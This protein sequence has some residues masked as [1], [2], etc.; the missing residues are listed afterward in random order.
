VRFFAREAV[1]P[2]SPSSAVDRQ[3]PDGLFCLVLAAGLSKR[4]GSAKQLADFRGR[5][6][7]AH[8]MHLAG[9]VFGRASIL[10]AGNQWSR[11]TAAA[12]PLEG[13]FVVNEQYRHGL[14]SSIAA[15]ASVVGGCASGVMLLMADQPLIEASYLSQMIDEWNRDRDRIVVSQFDGVVGPPVIFPSRYFDELRA[16]DGDNGARKII[17]ANVSSLTRLPCAAAATDIDRKE[18]LER[19]LDRIR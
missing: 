2:A 11:V 7:I 14:G 6:M 9:E 4:F 8:T 13:F 16:L 5:P 10:V 12:A 15:G 18:D 1:L 3:A 19:V 17:E